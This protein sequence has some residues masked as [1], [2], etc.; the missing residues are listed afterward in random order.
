M[1]KVAH[2]SSF[3]APAL[4][5]IVRGSS[6]GAE[7]LGRLH[8]KQLSL[9]YAQRWFNLFVPIEYGGLELSLPE[10]LKIE[11]GLA[12][13]DGST[14]WT[15]TLCSGANW[16]IGFLKKSQ[17]IFNNDRTC[18]AGSGY[19]S[20]IAKITSRGYEITGRWK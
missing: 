1:K 17:E 5:A 10:G 19:P 2:P 6:S 12:W 15:V 20:G 7:Q 9:I 16:F 13:A 8:P 11:E 18:L 3:I 4:S 14:G